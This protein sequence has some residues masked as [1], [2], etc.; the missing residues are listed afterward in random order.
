MG[1]KKLAKTYLPRDVSLPAPPRLAEMLKD[2]SG[3]VLLDTLRHHIQD[4][5]HHSS[6]QLQIKVRFH[7]L[8]GHSLGNTLRVST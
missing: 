6:S 2:G 3:L 1:S 4:V 7:T 8:F 5:M